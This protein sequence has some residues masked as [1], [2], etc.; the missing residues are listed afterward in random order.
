MTSPISVVPI[1][2]RHVTSPAYAPTHRRHWIPCTRSYAVV[3]DTTALT[4]QS[5]AQQIDK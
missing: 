1:R 3:E 5:S 4:S 2:R